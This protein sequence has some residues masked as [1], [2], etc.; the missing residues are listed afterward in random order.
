MKVLR[1]KGLGF[2]GWC[3]CSPFGISRKKRNSGQRTLL[4]R[5]HLAWPGLVGPGLPSLDE[6]S[7]VSSKLGRESFVHVGKPPPLASCWIRV[8]FIK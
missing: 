5:A 3:S 7:E 8:G 4:S 6:A 2:E 1:R